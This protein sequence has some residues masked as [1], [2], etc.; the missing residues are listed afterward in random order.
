MKISIPLLVR[1]ALSVVLIYCVY[2]ETGPATAL[3][4]ALTVIGSEISGYET[5]ELIQTVKQLTKSLL[6]THELL[7]RLRK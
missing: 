2:R 4:A 6:T 5:D 1:L 7:W 3:F